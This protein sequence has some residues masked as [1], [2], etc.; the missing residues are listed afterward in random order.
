MIM[1]I[2]MSQTRTSKSP[3]CVASLSFVSMRICSSSVIYFVISYSSK[4]KKHQLV[5]QVFSFLFCIAMSHVL[6]VFFRF[7]AIASVNLQAALWVSLSRNL[8]SLNGLLS[9]WWF[10]GE[11]TRTFLSRRSAKINIL[12]NNLLIPTS[13]SLLRLST[14]ASSSLLCFLNRLS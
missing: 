14:V 12:F 6:E 10:A 8:Y 7:S 5:I 13:S 9:L 2:M 3:L 4:Y 1:V 11:K